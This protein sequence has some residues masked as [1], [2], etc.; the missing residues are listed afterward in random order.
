MSLARPF[1]S[2]E[3]KFGKIEGLILTQNLTRI[4]NM[5]SILAENKEVNC[6]DNFKNGGIFGQRYHIR[7]QFC[8]FLVPDVVTN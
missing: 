2:Q 5:L 6:F 7:Y 8:S 3:R 1:F 4:S